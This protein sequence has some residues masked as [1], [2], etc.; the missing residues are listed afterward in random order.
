MNPVGFGDVEGMEAGEAR[1]VVHESVERTG[2][3]LHLGEELS[4]SATLSRLL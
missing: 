4:I 1:G 3:I 2:L